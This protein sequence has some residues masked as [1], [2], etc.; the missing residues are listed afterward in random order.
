MQSAYSIMCNLLEL[1]HITREKYNFIDDL[2]L[3]ELVEA[4]IILENELDL[5]PY[6]LRAPNL[7]NEAEAKRRPPAQ[8]LDY[9]KDY[10]D[11]DIEYLAGMVIKSGKFPNAKK[12]NLIHELH[13]SRLFYQRCTDPDIDFMVK[14]PPTDQTAYIEPLRFVLIRKSNHQISGD[15][16][17]M[18][19]L[20]NS[21]A[22]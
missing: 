13:S 18:A 14:Y 20:L 21:W 2:I 11:S 12:E 22:L 1:L 8:H 6:E 7:I 4:R 10:S 15:S 9:V 16:T 19:E 5:S 3:D 17:N